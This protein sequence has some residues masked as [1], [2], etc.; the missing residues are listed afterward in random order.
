MQCPHCQ[1]QIEIPDLWEFF[2]CTNCKASLQ[3]ENNELKILKRPSE[4]TDPHQQPIPQDTPESQNISPIKPIPEKTNTQN[5]LDN[6]DSHSSTSS[7]DPASSPDN[8]ELPQ[9]PQQSIEDGSPIEPPLE[10]TPEDFSKNSQNSPSSSVED[11]SENNNEQVFTENETHSPSSEQSENLSN[12]LD[13]EHSPNQKNHFTYY[14]QIS[15]IPSKALL[16]KIQSIFKS[17]RLKLDHPDQSTNNSLAV[18]N[19]NAVQM[20]YILRK[21]SPLPVQIHWRQK[22]TLKE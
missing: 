12:I 16:D 21:L 5:F 14:L 9:N 11:T 19:L 20:V 1:T 18:N 7:E 10:T 22:S 6:D 2:D 15:G 8:S 13:F 17:P 3:L 4:K